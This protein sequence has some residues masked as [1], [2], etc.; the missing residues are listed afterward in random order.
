MRWSSIWWPHRC[1]TC[2]RIRRTPLWTRSE[3]TR[4]KWSWANTR[5]PSKLSTSSIKSSISE[6]KDTPN[7]TCT[8]AATNQ[9]LKTLTKRANSL[10]SHWKRSCT[11]CNTTSPSSTIR[12][13]SSILR[14]AKLKGK[15]K[16]SIWLKKSRGNYLKLRNWTSQSLKVYPASTMSQ[17]RKSKNLVQFLNQD[18]ILPWAMIP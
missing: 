2:P 16:G 1:T 5:C 12:E 14:C 13:L 8:W 6:N 7:K 11:R 9:E 18:L 15:L 10:F 3:T 17:Q 4:K